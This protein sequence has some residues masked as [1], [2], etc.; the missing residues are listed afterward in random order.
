VNSLE[1]IARIVI[2]IRDLRERIEEAEDKR[3]VWLELLE[4]GALKVRLEKMK[5]RIMQTK[6]A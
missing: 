2:R 1:E 4:V 3:S 5:H 6:E